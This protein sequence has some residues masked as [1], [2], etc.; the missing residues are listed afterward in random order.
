[1]TAPVQGANLAAGVAWLSKVSAL[2]QELGRSRTI[3]LAMPSGTR[4]P[5]RTLAPRRGPAPT[6]ASIV[7]VALWQITGTRRM[8]AR[9]MYE[10]NDRARGYLTQRLL[11]RF[12]PQ[13]L[14]G[15]PEPN[16]GAML[17][18]AGYAFRD[19]LVQRMEAGGGDLTLT[20]LT[21]RYAGYKVRL[22]YPARIGTMTG[23]T[24][25]AVRR[26]QP[27]VRRR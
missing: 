14:D 18:V 27:I 6:Q 12:T 26:A 16:V 13:L 21:A 20:P 9:D 5:P 7:Q 15:D 25:N 1:M 10:L 17:M 11:T 4:E 3:E 22:G 2:V 23:Q 19:L 8:P 24:L